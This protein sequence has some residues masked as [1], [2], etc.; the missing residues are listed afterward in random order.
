[1]INSVHV[2]Q[3]FSHV[4]TLYS[5]KYKIH[6]NDS[7]TI[8]LTHILMVEIRKIGISHLYTNQDFE[9]PKKQDIFRLRRGK[10]KRKLKSDFPHKSASKR[11]RPH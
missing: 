3:T 5:I 7:D 2:K 1:M 9:I 11:F 4:W 10:I 8:L 6:T